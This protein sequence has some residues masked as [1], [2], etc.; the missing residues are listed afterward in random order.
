MTTQQQPSIFE[1]HAKKTAVGLLLIIIGLLYLVFFPK[2]FNNSHT[3]YED[4]SLK[5]ILTQYYFSRVIDNNVKRFIKLR[6]HEPNKSK[7]DRPSRNYVKNI[8]GHL[9]RRYYAM[10]IES[11]GFIA[12]SAVHEQPDIKVVFLG[13]STTECL[14]M[15][16]D[17]RFPYL[18][19]R[20]LEKKLGLKVNSYNGGVSANESMH[21]INIL[22]NKVLP[23]KPDMVV[24]MHNINDL[25]MLRLHGNYHYP[26]SLKSHL[27]TA[28][29]VFTHVE[30]PKGLE[31]IENEKIAQAFQKNLEMFIA[32]CKIHQTQPVLMTQANRVEDDDL[33]HRFNQII[34]ET[35]NK[36]KIILI[37]LAKHIPKSLDLI[38]DHYHYTEIGSNQSAEIIAS[39]LQESIKNTGKS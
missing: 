12:P 22:L 28:K 1:Q 27:Q 15:D 9:E 13:G 3:E 20:L 21:S 4:K 29:N 37:D 35:A 31:A 11:N 17:K 24:M 30:Y 6:E 8:P 33:Y 38:Y 10:D 7:P 5:T 14:Y 36:N 32:I 23:M 19:G 39:H 26:N 18:V 2:W 25:V 16:A 34:R